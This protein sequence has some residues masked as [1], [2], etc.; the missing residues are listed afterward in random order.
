M[1][2]LQIYGLSLIPGLGYMDI[3]PNSGPLWVLFVDGA[4]LI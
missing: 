3:A 2:C 4:R 1:N